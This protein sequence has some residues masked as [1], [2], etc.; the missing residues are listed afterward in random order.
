MRCTLAA[1]AHDA[2]RRYGNAEALAADDRTLRFADLDALA[3]RFAA[4]LAGLGIG[5]GDRVVLHLPNGWQW[6][7]AYHALARLGA[8]V[9]P[10]NILL[11]MVEIGFMVD[12]SGA[13]AV[14][15]PA[16]RAP[17]LA[18]RACIAITDLAHEG[19]VAF[20]D[21]LHGDWLAPVEAASDDLFTIAYT[22]GTTGKPKGAMLTHGNVFASVSQTATIHVRTRRDRVYSALPFPHV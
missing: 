21:L 9:V 8:V 3:G 13:R 11:T 18:G 22:S 20:D 1:L 15:L 12:D 17:G 14:I 7:V 2:G 6:V 10:A 16:D 4:G 19:H 5:A